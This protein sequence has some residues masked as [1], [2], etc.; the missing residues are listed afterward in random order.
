[1]RTRQI[2]DLSMFVV[3][4]VQFV[5]IAREGTR[6]PLAAKLVAN[7]ADNQPTGKK[8][9]AFQKY[10][11]IQLYNMLE[12]GVDIDSTDEVRCRQC[13]CTCCCFCISD[14]FAFPARRDGA[15]GCGGQR[16]RTRAPLPAPATPL[17]LAAADRPCRKGEQTARYEG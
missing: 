11:V 1:M 16:P 7:G 8:A 5:E 15:H 3:D 6:R 4:H 17:G 2:L 14:A 10:A 13:R 9:R 12:A